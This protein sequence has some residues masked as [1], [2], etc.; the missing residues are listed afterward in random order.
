MRRA[1]KADLQSS[2]D[3]RAKIAE[4]TVLVQ[5]RLRRLI[6]EPRSAEARHEPERRIWQRRRQPS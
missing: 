6:D 5:R 2:A 1:L 4:E 3:D